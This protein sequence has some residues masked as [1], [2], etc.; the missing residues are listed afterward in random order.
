MTRDRSTPPQAN[1]SQTSPTPRR[2]LPSASLGFLVLTYSVLGWTIA[3]FGQP[4]WLWWLLS[5]LLGLGLS[6]L[7]SLPLSYWRVPMRWFRS[8]MVSFLSVFVGAF[9]VVLLLAWIHVLMVVLLLLSAM[10][11]ARLDLLTARFPRWQSGLI[12]AA[13]SQIGLA[14]GW[15][16]HW[17]MLI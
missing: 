7:L 11:L 10:T 4:A 13:T 15:M 2:K 12:L 1:R 14:S 8:E 9:T 16:L 5:I 17:L 3:D 6:L